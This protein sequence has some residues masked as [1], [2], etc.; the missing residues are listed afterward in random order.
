MIIIHESSK[1]IVYCLCHKAFLDALE[2]GAQIVGT[3]ELIEVSRPLFKGKKTHLKQ[4]Y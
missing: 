1:C 4:K 3:I 2:G